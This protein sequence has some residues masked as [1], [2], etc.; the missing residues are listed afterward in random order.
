MWN[1]EKTFSIV[2]KLSEFLRP[3][4]KKSYLWGERDCTPLCDYAD[5]RHELQ[6]TDTGGGIGY[7]G[8]QYS[9]WDFALV[10]LFRS[11]FLEAPIKD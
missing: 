6:N 7:D 3:I 4:T 9:V 5:G 8:V 1:M 11:L 2:K 10:C